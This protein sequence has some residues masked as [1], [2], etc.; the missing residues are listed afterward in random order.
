MTIKSKMM[1]KLTITVLKK[2]ELPF[3]QEMSYSN[4]VKMKIINQM[5]NKM[6]FSIFELIY[7]HLI[8]YSNLI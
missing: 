8:K 6:T 4:Q 5:L 3:I 1:V 7:L 2:Q